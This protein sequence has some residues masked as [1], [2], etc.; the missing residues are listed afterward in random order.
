MSSLCATSSSVPAARTAAFSFFLSRMRCNSANLIICTKKLG[1]RT[2]SSLKAPLLTQLCCYC[3]LQALSTTHEGE[4][5][6][7]VYILNPRVSVEE[8]LRQALYGSSSINFI[9]AYFIKWVLCLLLSRRSWFFGMLFRRRCVP[10]R[11][12]LYLC[13]PFVGSGRKQSRRLGFPE[14]GSAHGSRLPWG[15]LGWLTHSGLFY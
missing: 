10:R 2:L 13:R 12:L 6:E 7:R 15:L 14:P 4:A 1:S 9:S 11:P 5:P 8:G 3:R